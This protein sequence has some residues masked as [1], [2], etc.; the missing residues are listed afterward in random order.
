MHLDTFAHSINN[1]GDITGA[2]DATQAVTPGFIFEG[3]RYRTIYTPHFQ[4]PDYVVP[5]TYGRALS[6]VRRISE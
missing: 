5:Q 4:Y 3:S 1:R 2:Y 6:L